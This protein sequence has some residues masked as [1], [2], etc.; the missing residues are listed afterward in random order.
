MTDDY[1]NGNIKDILEPMI[2]ALIMAQPEDPKYFMLQWLKHLYSLDYVRSN[3][4]KEELENLRLFIKN[5]KEGKAEKT[6]KPNKVETQKSGTNNIEKEEEPSKNDTS[7]VKK[8]N[9]KD[10]L[11]FSSDSENK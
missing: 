4:D 6:E 2:S 7:T 5:S 1:L 8:Q 9:K 3:P 10:L 11:D